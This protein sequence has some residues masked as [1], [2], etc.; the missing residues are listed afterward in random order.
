MYQPA[1]VRGTKSPAGR[2]DSALPAMMP[3]PWRFL[4]FRCRAVR[5]VYERSQSRVERF[6]MRRSLPPNVWLS[7]ALVLAVTIGPAATGADKEWKVPRTSWGAPDLQ[8]T[9]TNGSLTS[10][11]RDARFKDKPFLSAAEAK[12]FEQN[13]LF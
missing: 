6:H 10:L 12:A 2:N 5:V 1:G 8:G 3:R 13:N 7:A 11:E 4:F 9:W